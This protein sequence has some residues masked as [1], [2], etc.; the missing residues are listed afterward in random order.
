MDPSFSF[1]LEEVR[2]YRLKQSNKSPLGVPSVTACQQ[3]EHYGG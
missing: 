2:Y 1:S 3:W